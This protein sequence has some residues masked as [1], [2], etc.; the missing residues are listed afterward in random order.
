M[1][2]KNELKDADT[3]ALIFDIDGTL[4]RWTSVPDLLGATLAHFNV[5]YTDDVMKD[6]FKAVNYY[7]AHLLISSRASVDEY[8]SILGMTMEVLKKH[9]ISGRDFKDWMFF[10][11]AFYTTSEEGIQEELQA[12][13]KDYL[14]CCYTNW[15]KYQAIKKLERHGIN[16]FFD[17]FYSFENMYIKFSSVGFKSILL[18]LGLEP[19]NVIHI[20]DS[21]SD[22]VCR[23]AGIPCVLIDYDQNKERLY[24]SADAIVTEFRDISRLLKR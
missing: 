20:G 2:L 14:L 4:T 5:P 22:L 23:C 6:F 3:K 19:S 7:E 18:E 10:E 8:A 11:E 13:Q 1:I 21:D 15:F 9:G 12:L 16:D 17:H 24:D